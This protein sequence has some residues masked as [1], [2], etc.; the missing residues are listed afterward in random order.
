MAPRPL[1]RALIAESGSLI[2]LALPL[3]AGLASATMLGT[4][5][6]VM[7]GPLGSV[8]LAAVSVVASILMMLYAGLYGFV[9][10]V[11]IL[12][13]QAYGAEDPSEVGS[14][15]RHGLFLGLVGGLLGSLA[16]AAGLLALPFLE[17][18]DDVVAIITPYWL[19][20]AASL[21]PF[22]LS[23]V[24]KGMLD[25]VDRA[26]TG[27][28]LLLVPLA[29]NAFLNWVLIYGHLGAPALG[30]TGAGVASF[31]GQCAGLFAM[32]LVVHRAPS[33]ARYRD[34]KPLS[35][36]AFF[37]QARE[38]APMATQYL[39]EGGSAAIGGLMIGLFGAVALAANQIA[40]S[41][42]SILYMLPL[43]M[44]AAVSIRIAQAAG[45][46]APERLGAIG[47]AGI[48]LVTVWTTAFTGLLIA[49]GEAIAGMIVSD[50]VLIAAAATFFVVFALMQVIDGIQSVALGAL[51][52][53]LDNDWPTI[54][55]LIA[56]WLIALPVAWLVAFR[57]GF[58]APGV[59]A[60]FG[61]GLA[62]AAVALV[63]RFER[64]T[65]PL[66]RN[67]ADGAS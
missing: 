34:R 40:S 1:R 51:R 10:P 52:G 47:Y 41:V 58:G 15:L 11:G 33:L 26:W 4:I 7:L 18:P 66:R 53:I 29:V 9:G 39:L 12:V 57:F 35:V 32:A 21:V 54:V 8:P 38:G 36:I 19:W 48:G 2:V 30:L 17:Q 23:L 28:A 64:K 16:M 56:Y 3:V 61:A 50:P 42:T 49:F 55:S 25:A 6:T 5:D 44:S 13:G 31:I 67:G 43:G 45:A 14:I 59:W 62:V 24:Y 20:M 27:T 22:T 65:R 63:W 60:G 37:R 46:G